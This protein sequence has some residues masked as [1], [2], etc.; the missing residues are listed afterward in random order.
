MTQLQCRLRVGKWCLVLGSRG[1][2]G[3][4]RSRPGRGQVAGSD[5]SPGR[6]R[7]LCLSLELAGV[8]AG[9]GFC[10]DDVYL[11]RAKSLLD[12]GRCCRATCRQAAAPVPSRSRVLCSSPVSIL[13]LPEFFKPKPFSST[14]SCKPIV[15]PYCHHPGLPS[16][17]H[18]TWL[19]APIPWWSWDKRQRRGWAVSPRLLQPLLLPRAAAV[20]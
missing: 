12:S 10:C 19:P 18:P 16:Q 13:H 15:F 3:R 20:V 1:A 5:R 8:Q 14:I 11:S 7:D 4:G 2:A 9:V 6:G 17:T